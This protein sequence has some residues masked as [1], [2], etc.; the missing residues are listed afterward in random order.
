MTRRKPP[1]RAGI[2]SRALPKTASMSADEIMAALENMLA[3]PDHLAEA[4]K[5]LASVEAWCAITL[6]EQADDYSAN[7]LL[8]F[9]RGVRASAS[10]ARRDRDALAPDRQRDWA[11][12]FVHGYSLMLAYKNAREEFLLGPNFRTGLNTR[13]AN[14]ENR[15]KGI[16]AFKSNPSTTQKLALQVAV[17][18]RER[19]P[20]AT[21]ADIIRACHRQSGAEL[22]DERQI[23]RWIKAWEE[24]GELPTKV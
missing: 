18:L 24:R 21:A 13:E 12:G 20:S 8:G 2:H 14:A 22:P 23:R 4:E 11:A 16:E 15:A 10:V 19:R 5:G 1:T 6:A 9:A 7:E 17:S 3:P